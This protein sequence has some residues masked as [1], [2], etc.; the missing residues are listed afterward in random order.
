MILLPSTESHNGVLRM[1][2]TNYCNKRTGYVRP[3]LTFSGAEPPGRVFLHASIV[4]YHIVSYHIVPYHVASYHIV[5]YHIVPY[6]VVS[7][8]IVP[9]QIVPYQIVPYQIVQSSPTISSHTILYH[10]ISS[11]TNTVRVR[12]HMGIYRLP[13][14]CST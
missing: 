14:K 13:S 7:Y 2:G 1:M 5:P 10:T 11:H 6:H 3:N 8:H 12:S 9:Y 4:S